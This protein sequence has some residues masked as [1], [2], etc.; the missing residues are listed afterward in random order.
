VTESVQYE[1]LND[2]ATTHSSTADGLAAGLDMSRLRD[3]PMSLSVEIGRTQMTV[4]ETLALRVGSV[5]TLARLAGEPVDLLVNGAPIARG[6]V[7]VLE[8]RFALHVTELIAGQE[9]S[10]SV[11]GSR[12]AVA[13][14]GTADTVPVPQDPVTADGAGVAGQ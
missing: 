6:E 10:A 13:A 4:S 8:D 14:S 1:P 5:V 3:I 7:T 11:A 2:D 9:I 12:D